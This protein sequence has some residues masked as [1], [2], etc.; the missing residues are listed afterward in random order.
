[1]QA[2]GGTLRFLCWKD[3]QP[4]TRRQHLHV[5]DKIHVPKTLSAIPVKCD[6]RLFVRSFGVCFHLR[7][8]AIEKLISS[9]RFSNK[10][11]PHHEVHCAGNPWLHGLLNVR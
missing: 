10:D 11:D 3:E 2:T 5:V 8:H 4:R 7:R 1:M 6:P 9:M